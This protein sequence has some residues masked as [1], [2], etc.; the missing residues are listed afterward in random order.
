MYSVWSNDTY[1]S[2]EH[3]ARVNSER[4]RFSIP[5]FFYPAHYTIV[6]PLEE[7]VSEKNPPKYKPYNWGKFFVSRKTSYFK[8]LDVENI[9]IYHFRISN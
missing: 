9:Q 7:L 3:R 4:E 1:E 6:K 5:F 8:K 2:V